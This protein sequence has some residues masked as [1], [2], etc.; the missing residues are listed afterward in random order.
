LLDFI[1]QAALQHSQKTNACELVKRN[2]TFDFI[3]N[4]LTVSYLNNRD[5]KAQAINC[6]RL[7]KK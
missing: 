6:E 1:I 7:K 5:Y 2:K 4:K 3:C